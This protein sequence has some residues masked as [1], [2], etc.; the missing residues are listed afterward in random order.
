MRGI[1][2]KICKAKYHNAQQNHNTYNAVCITEN[3]TV[4]DYKRHAEYHRNE[5]LEQINSCVFQL[6]F[7]GQRTFNHGFGARLIE[8]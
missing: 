6:F 2:T 4:P 8:L 1:N 5:N 7:T 3:L